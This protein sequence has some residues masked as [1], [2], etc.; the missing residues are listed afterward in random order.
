MSNFRV[1][2]ES[3]KIKQRLLPEHTKC[4]SSRARGAPNAFQFGGGKRR[5]CGYLSAAAHQEKE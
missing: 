3:P 4:L 2:S 5:I 1:A